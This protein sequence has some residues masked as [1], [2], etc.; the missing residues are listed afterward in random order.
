MS[1]SN[2]THYFVK[3]LRK[4]K[5]L[6]FDLSRVLVVDDT[7]QKLERNYGNALYVQ[8]YFGDAADDELPKLASYLRTLVASEDVRQVEKRGWRYSATMEPQE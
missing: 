4:V 1:P 6:G 3:D 8:P 5:R 2:Q 7:P